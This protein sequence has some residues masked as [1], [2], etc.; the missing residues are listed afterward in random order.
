[1]PFMEPGTFALSS[2]CALAL[3]YSRNTWHPLHSQS[4]LHGSL[5][6]IHPSILPSIPPSRDSMPSHSTSFEKVVL[7]CC[8]WTSP[9]INIYICPLTTCW[10]TKCPDFFLFLKKTFFKVFSQLWPHHISLYNLPTQSPSNLPQ[11]GPIARDGSTWKRSKLV[12]T[13]KG[14]TSPQFI[15]HGL[16]PFKSIPSRS[17]L[18]RGC[19]LTS[20][21]QREFF[22]KGKAVN[23]KWNRIRTHELSGLLREITVH[24]TISFQW[25]K[26]ILLTLFR[27]MRYIISCG[28]VSRL[29][30][31]LPLFRKCYCQMKADIL[32]HPFIFIR[33]LFIL[34]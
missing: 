10:F 11:A 24:S 33:L 4:Y 21:S 31:A 8:H 20:F 25:L 12:E 9:K 19:R 17:H 13:V 28:T 30:C 34:C 6:S 27:T 29:I 14:I 16:L 32:L 1:M 23:L 26:Q 7:K 3:S 15:C 18:K 22:T 5:D 2:M